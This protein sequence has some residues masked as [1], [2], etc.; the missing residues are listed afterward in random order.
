MF[1]FRRSSFFSIFALFFCRFLS[2]FFPFLQFHIVNKT[3]E[4]VDLQQATL[5]D[6]FAD[7][8]SIDSA[9]LNHLVSCN[10]ENL[11]SGEI[12]VKT[13]LHSDWSVVTFLWF[14]HP[15]RISGRYSLLKNHDIQ[16]LMLANFARF[17][18]WKT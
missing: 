7:W 4:E 16:L 17:F 2:I 9:K 6:I 1:F 13:S 3:T 10:L 8:L 18:S 5:K 12:L 15:Y 14:I 11:W